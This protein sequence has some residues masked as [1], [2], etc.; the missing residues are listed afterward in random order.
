MGLGNQTRLLFA[1]LV[2]MWLASIAQEPGGLPAFASEVDLAVSDLGTIA[3]SAE[4]ALAVEEGKHAVAYPD[5]VVCER[6]PQTGAVRMD[7]CLAPLADMSA[8]D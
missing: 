3:R 5:G 4:S 8:G 1:S 7:E 2:L 6:D